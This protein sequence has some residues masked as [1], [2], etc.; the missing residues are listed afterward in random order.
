MVSQWFSE[1]CNLY[2]GE[3]GQA[4]GIRDKASEGGR[5]GAITHED[6]CK[7][8][9]RLRERSVTVPSR[10]GGGKATRCNGELPCAGLVL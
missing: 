4:R 7:C 6:C 8:C 9:L 3:V 10:V 1:V 5:L 2:I